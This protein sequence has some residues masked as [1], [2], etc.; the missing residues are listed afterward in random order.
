MRLAAIA[1][2]ALASYP[3][4]AATLGGQV[5]EDHSGA[6][7]ASVELKVAREGVRQLVADLETDASGHFQ[8]EGIPPG[9]YR[10]EVLKPNYASL[11]LSLH[12]DQDARPL[13][14]RLVRFGVISGRVADADNR[15]IAGARVTVFTRRGGAL[16]PFG[17]PLTP[18]ERGRYRIYNL[19]PGEY[20]VAVS[21]G[22]ASASVSSGGV[23]L[24]STVGSGVRLY[25]SNQRP[26]W[27]TVAGGEDYPNTDFIVM[28]AGL[29][30]VSGTVEP[31]GGMYAVALTAVDQ[32][33]MPVATAR[34]DSNSNV[35]SLEG[36]PSGSYNLYAVG[37]AS[38]YGYGGVILGPNPVY[39]RVRVDVIGQDVKAVA[40]PVEKGL[41]AS[42][43]L[44]RASEQQPANAC[45]PTASVRLTPVESRGAMLDRTLELNFEK[46][47]T[48]VDLAPGRYRLVA[49]KAGDSCYSASGEVDLAVSTEEPIAV[50]VAAAAALKGRLRGAARPADFAIVLALPNAPE[51]APAVQTAYPDSQ[52]RFSFAGL[53]PGRYRIAAVPTAG[54]KAR[55]VADMARMTEL[56]L[57]GGATEIDL[58][59]PE[60]K[61]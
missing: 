14:L 8:A 49:G 47:Q 28:P 34:L 51:G 31:A 29:S 17:S 53:P 60:V 40:I 7:L 59:A 48:A 11:G 23:G 20:A 42:F 61:Q 30:T 43:I 12:L 36:I 33:V 37:P 52:A 41:S 15:Q 19:P 1:A 22:A 4:G 3:L 35:F 21:Y 5:L 58:P 6:P 38:G 44:K 54:P 16:E 50:T 32:P 56:D 18:D 2:F 26:Q 13:A 55:W 25:Q 46:P 57:T 39:G 9:D 27:F 10:I 45:P 24:K